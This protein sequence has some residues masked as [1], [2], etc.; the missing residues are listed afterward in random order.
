MY[1]KASETTQRRAESRKNDARKG[2]NGELGAMTTQIATTE[3]GGNAERKVTMWRGRRRC[4]V[5]YGGAQN[6]VVM[7]GGEW[8]CRWRYREP[9]GDADRKMVL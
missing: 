5:A 2:G 6:E 8:R 1:S 4:G 3:A 9:V 7:Q